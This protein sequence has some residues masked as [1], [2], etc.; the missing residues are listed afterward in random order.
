MTPLE[1]VGSAPEQS[2]DRQSF[3]ALLRSHRASAGLTQEQLAE[4]AGLSRRGIA[5]LERGARRSPYASTVDR[6][7]TALGLSES[8]RTELAAATRRIAVA[9]SPRRT[10][11]GRQAELH[12]L[13]EACDAAVLGVGN[14]HLLAGEP[15]IGKTA[16]CEQLTTY[17]ASRGLCSLAGHCYEEGS[18]S[19]PY[20]PFVEALR[21]YMRTRTSDELRNELGF[22]AN[23]LTRVMPELADR[24]EVGP[25]SPTTPEED[26]WQLL[27]SFCDAFCAVASR[28]PLLVVIEDM[29]WAR[30]CQPGPARRP[31]PTRCSGTCARGGHLP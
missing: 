28:T 9:K 18:L 6:L 24:L 22:A 20:L 16:L 4:L 14:L 13:Q 26:R 2:H 11:V 12:Q 8:A 25:R 5:D 1:Q 10:F 15:G 23:D 29:Q 31:E 21:S 19:I 17:A 3:G 30:P 27:G 7:A